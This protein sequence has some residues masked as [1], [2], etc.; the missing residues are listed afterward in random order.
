MLF[1]SMEPNGCLVDKASLPPPT[2]NEAE[3][4]QIQVL[5]PSTGDIIWSLP[6]SDRGVEPDYWGLVATPA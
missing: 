4:C 6:S 3:I 2:E 5:P 1:N